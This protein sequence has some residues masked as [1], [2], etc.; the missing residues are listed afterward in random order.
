MSPRHVPAS[1]TE[2][3]RVGLLSSLPGETLA[4]LA[5]RMTRE[6][7]PGGSTIVEEGTEG[8]R[9]YVLLS[10][11]A[12]VTQVSRGARSM[13]RPGET[14]GEVALAMGVPRTATITTM[15]PSVVASCDRETF[16]ELLRPLFADDE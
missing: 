11:L 7:V 8:D 14:F 16:D 5:E 6:E 9:F 13:L 15:L 2:L 3:S 12:S 10:G 1:V 4:R